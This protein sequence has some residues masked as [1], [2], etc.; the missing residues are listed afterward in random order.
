M[1]SES[2]VKTFFWI[3]P[4]IEIVIVYTITYFDEAISCF[5]VLISKHKY[6][7]LESI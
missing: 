1:F 5:N 6:L 7:I 2:R 3:F 4:P